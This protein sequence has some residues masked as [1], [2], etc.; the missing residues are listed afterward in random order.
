MSS[1]FY[2]NLIVLFLTKIS[3]MNL[4]QRQMG[5]ADEKATTEFSTCVFS[6]ALPF[7]K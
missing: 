7:P 5:T 2:I 1:F 4:K 6:S 3:N